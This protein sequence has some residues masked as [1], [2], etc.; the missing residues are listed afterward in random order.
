MTIP[1]LD[2]LFLEHPRSVGQG[3]LEHLL[4]AHRFGGRM[5]RGALAA[6]IHGLFPRVCQTAAGDAVRALHA[7]LD[8]RDPKDGAGRL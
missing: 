6:F 7:S 2:R 4:F 5:L 8:R 3:Y 1:I